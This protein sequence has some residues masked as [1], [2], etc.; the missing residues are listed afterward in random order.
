MRRFE[1]TSDLESIV[2]NGQRCLRST[3]TD[4]SES[5]QV[6]R[7]HLSLFFHGWMNWDQKW[8]KMLAQYLNGFRR[9]RSSTAQASLTTFPYSLTS[10]IGGK[11]SL[12][13]AN[14]LVTLQWLF[15][16]RCQNTFSNGWPFSDS[17]VIG[18][19]MPLVM[20]DSSVTLQWLFSH[21]CQNAFSNDWLFSDSSVMEQHWVTY[22]KAF[23]TQ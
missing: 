20:A 19:K 8:S 7:K 11:M 14:S 4:S 15:N 3:W 1:Y 23:C 12:V 22:T 2:D 13:M 16:H 17:S 9:I 18:V 21:R 5:V 6:L 10:I